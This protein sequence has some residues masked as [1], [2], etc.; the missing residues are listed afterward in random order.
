VVFALQSK[1][2]PQL[3]QLHPNQEK[4]TQ[5]NHTKKNS[6]YPISPNFEVCFPSVDS[7]KIMHLERVCCKYQKCIKMPAF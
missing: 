4:N 5:L 1:A 3:E 6:F 7:K 2:E